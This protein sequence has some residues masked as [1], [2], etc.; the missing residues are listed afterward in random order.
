MAKE[1]KLARSSRRKDQVN[2]GVLRTNDIVAKMAGASDDFV[3]AMP[4]NNIKNLEHGHD[5]AVAPPAGEFTKPG[6]DKL[7][8]S[9]VT[10]Q[11]GTAKTGGPA[12]IGA[13]ANIA[14]LDQFKVDPSG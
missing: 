6:S 7:T 9:T 12:Q 10:E 13:N 8:A 14:L 5:N 11:P 4:F 1:K 2:D 3:A